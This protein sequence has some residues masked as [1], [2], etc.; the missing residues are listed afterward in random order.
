MVVRDPSACHIQ[1][2]ANRTLKDTIV[3]L[4]LEDEQGGNRGNSDEEGIEVEVHGKGMDMK[5]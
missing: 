1:R 4:E 2:Q 3:V 5:P